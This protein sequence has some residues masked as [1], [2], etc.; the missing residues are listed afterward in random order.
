[1][2]GW[3]PKS[4]DPRVASTRIRCLNPLRELRRRGYPVELFRPEHASDYSAVVYSKLYDE[5][6]YHEAAILRAKGARIVVDLCDNYFYNP[7][8]VPELSRARVALER[9]LR[10]ADHLVASTPE[11]A[12]VMRGELGPKHP[13]TVIG[14]AVENDIVGVEE[15][16][17]RRWL[18]RRE[19]H[20]LL[21]WLESGRSTGLK[22]AVVWFGIHGGPHHEHGMGDLLRVRPLLEE[23]HGRYGIQL[24]VISNSRQK[25]A[26]LIA[27][28]SLPTRYL[29]WSPLSF[30]PALRAH[31]IAV[32][33]V[34]PNP[35]T[36]CKSNNRLATALSVG[37]GVVADSVPSYRE[38][39]EA[40]R[41]DDWEQ[42]L[43]EYV[44]DPAVRSRD[45]RTGQALVAQLCSPERIADAW[46]EFFTAVTAHPAKG[47]Q[48]ET[49]QG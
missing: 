49:S 10:L 35:F 25:F 42:G 3:R 28:W 6:S 13:V 36:W 26:R 34:T 30:L 22:A 1:M 21:A 31:Q 33:P 2:I 43:S 9:M 41:L 48:L 14:D 29:E 47:A 46:Q 27:P 5:A 23:L 37:L 17:L 24:T 45:V 38:F 8:G 20:G 15:S 44:R 11:I 39:G 7:A 32:I 18:R 19:L 4:L 40:C 12:A 16:M